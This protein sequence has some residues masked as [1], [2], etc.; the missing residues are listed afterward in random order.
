LS[1]I[2]FAET[3]QYYAKSADQFINFTIYQAI[4][5]GTRGVTASVALTSYWWNFNNNDD[6]DDDD[7]GITYL[8][9]RPTSILASSV[10]AFTPLNQLKQSRTAC[11]SYIVHMHIN[12]DNIGSPS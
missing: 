12:I 4:R 5:Q 11:F 6:D 3:A 8:A 10:S 7:D 1:P 9:T 2:L